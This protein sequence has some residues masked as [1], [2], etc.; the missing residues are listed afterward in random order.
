M[1][2]RYSGEEKRRTLT[3]YLNARGGTYRSY[4][5]LLGETFAGRIDLL[6]QLLNEAHHPT[7]GRYK[8]S[9]LSELVASFLPG[10]YSVGTGFVLFPVESYNTEGFG[11][12]AESILAIDKHVPSKQFDII[13]YDSHSYPVIYRD[14]DVVVLRPEAVRS[15]I[16][17]KGRLDHDQ[18]DDIVGKFVDFAAKWR[19]CVRCYDAC[20]VTLKQKPTLLAMGFAVR[21]DSE[22]RP[23][24]DGARV[25][26]RI[27]QRYKEA[28]VLDAIDSSFPLISA[29]G[30]YRQHIV[31]A[32]RQ[33]ASTKNVRL[34]Y[35]T[36]PGTCRIDG[37]GDLDRTVAFLLERVHLSLETRL[38]TK[39]FSAPASEEWAMEIS[40]DD[41]LGFTELVEIP[42]EKLQRPR[43]D[44]Q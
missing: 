35:E 38:A 19:A 37:R 21:P 9:L 11:D 39:A 28:G 30:I 8:E 41:K 32:D 22:G 17:V 42:V 1:G 16:E 43:A 25:R 4:M 14:G 23:L 40:G 29:V 2:K 26:E 12:E 15:V 36:L 31:A 27:V 10:R 20:G 3:E 18:T 13:V 44:P 33:L 6:E 24:T 34:G 7:T 5:S